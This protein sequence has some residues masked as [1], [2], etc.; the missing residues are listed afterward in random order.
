VEEEVQQ[1]VFS[2]ARGKS[3]RPCLQEGGGLEETVS[4]KGGRGGSP[5]L[6]VPSPD[7]SPRLPFNLPPAHNHL[8]VGGR[9]RHFL[10]F[11]KEDF[12][13][14]P[15]LLQAMEGYHPPFMSPP[16]LSYPGVKF[17]TPS[18]GANSPLIDAE[19]AA[20]LEKGA[21]EEVALHPP[22][23]GFISIFLVQKKNGKMRTVINLKKLNAAHLDTPHFRMESPQDVRQAIRPGDWAAYIDLKDWYFHVPIAPDARKYLRLE[24]TPIPVL[25][26][27]LRPVSS[28]SDIYTPVQEGKG[29]A[30]LSGYSY[31][32]LPGRHLG[33][34]LNV[35]DLLVQH[36]GGPL[37]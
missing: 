15:Q 27:P 1:E 16:P 23:L 21:I 5:R 36:A 2:Q 26:P 4:L 22:P 7:T 19:V 34:G 18:Q 31:H 14:S 35:P 30:W 37:F 10:P 8:E 9:L 17:S 28:H 20:L 6:S 11:W 12:E 33:L 13:T 25:H 3:Q 24:K 29:Q 32:L